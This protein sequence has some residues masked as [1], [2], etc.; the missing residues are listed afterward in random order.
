MVR[1]AFVIDLARCVG[2]RS[3]ME[4]CKVEN[5]TTKGI[6]WMDVFK[7]EDG[8]YPNVKQYFLPRPCQHCTHPSCVPVCPV[9]ARFKREDGLVLTDFDRCIGCRYCI[10][11][12]PYGV[13]YFNW[14][15]PEDNDY[16]LWETEGKGELGSGSVKDG[17]RGVLPPNKNPDHERKYEGVNV[18]GGSHYMGVAEKCTWCVHRL[19]KGLSPACVQM[20][21][22]FVL[23]FG[24]MDD[25]ESKVSELVTTRPHFKLLEELGNEPN[26]F[27][28]NKTPPTHEARN[29]DI[30]RTWE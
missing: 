7:L 16:F 27:Y 28:I 8:E 5:N 26:V 9:G 4:A 20:C 3:C 11:A 29:L 30:R 14:K 12:C 22:M 21:P 10:V 25:P 17:T 23:N 13:G 24:D 2:C 15:K 1:Y 19:D 18:S 6:F